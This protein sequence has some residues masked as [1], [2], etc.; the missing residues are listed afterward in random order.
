MNQKDLDNILPHLQS[1]L[2]TMIEDEI[3]REKSL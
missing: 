1:S 3:G 2:I